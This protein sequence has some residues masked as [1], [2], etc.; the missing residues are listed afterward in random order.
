MI[1]NQKITKDTVVLYHAECS[2][3]F[4][5]AFA[6]WNKFGEEADYI[7][8][9]HQAPLPEGL[10]GKQIFFVDIV[11]A[12]AILKKVINDN[13]SV[14]AIDHHKTS[15]AKMNLFKE[16]SFDNNHSGSVLAWKYFNPEKSVPK[17]LLLIEDMDL[18]KWEYSETERFISALALY[19]YNFQTWD[20]IA[21][22]IENPERF[23]EYLK[24]GEVILEYNK[25]IIK[26]LSGAA[27]LVAFDSYKIYAVNAPHFINGR[28]AHNLIKESSPF[29]IAWFQEKDMIHVSLRSDGSVDV[30]E[31]AKKYGGGGHK[32]AAGFSFPAG[33][34]FPWKII[35]NE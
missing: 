3:G 35:K 7:P 5:G 10:N 16:H 6:A 24:K 8:I 2:D 15:E 20:K 4:G 22:D 14:I 21:S 13:I 29:A 18:W 27:I 25:N 19:D 23:S 28:V 9:E 30:S 11:P 34:E 33:Q 26:R 12:E 17:L 32:A 31:I 1:E